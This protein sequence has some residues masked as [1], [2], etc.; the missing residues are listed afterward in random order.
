ML[1]NIFK[2]FEKT[3]LC[4][5][6]LYRIHLE[7]K[8]FCNLT[9]SKPDFY[10]FC[11][12][13]RLFIPYSNK[14]VNVFPR[15]K[16]GFYL[17]FF[18]IYLSIIARILKIL[19]LVAI[20]ITLALFGIFFYYFFVKMP[21]YAHLYSEFFY[22]YSFYI[23]KLKQTEKLEVE[24]QVIINEQVIKLYGYKSI[25]VLNLL[26]Q[27]VSDNYK[28]ISRI[29][30]NTEYHERLMIYAL[31]CEIYIF[32]NLENFKH[33]NFLKQISLDLQLKQED[34]NVINKFFMDRETQYQQ[35]LENEYYKKQQSHKII[36]GTE[37]YYSILG[38]KPDSSI[39][40]I[41]KQFRYLSNLYHPDKYVNCTEEE[42]KQAEEKFKQIS[43]AYN[44]LKKILFIK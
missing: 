16:M 33:S 22:L 8:I 44:Q 19:P 9:F 32:N 21:I 7:G 34:L 41:K 13:F 6:C 12:S 24:K 4:R 11:P 27:K 40:E 43:F 15:E 31:L 30:K 25:K 38:L 35:R 36:T 3:A 17:I 10:A 14:Y 18:Y 28:I 37:D 1:E 2:F 5:I 23:K 26:Q 42:R 39:A 20:I 29:I